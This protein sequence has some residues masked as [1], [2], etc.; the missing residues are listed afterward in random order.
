M[1]GSLTLGPVSPYRAEAWLSPLPSPPQPAL[2]LLQ[3]NC[4]CASSNFLSIIFSY[5][6]FFHLFSGILKDSLR[7]FHCCLSGLCILLSA[8]IWGEF[9]TN[10]CRRSVPALLHVHLYHTNAH[11][12]QLC[13]GTVQSTHTSQTN[14]TLE[15]SNGGT[16][17]QSHSV[18]VL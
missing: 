14:W 7:F 11:L 15:V 10:S 3:S 17:L 12:F 6:T 5:W 8:W 13:L 16:L 2:T 1:K 18:V 4:T 9:S